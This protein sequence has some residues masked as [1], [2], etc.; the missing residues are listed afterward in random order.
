MEI[1]VKERESNNLNVTVGGVLILPENY[2]SDEKYHYYSTTISFYKYAKKQLEIDYLTKP[3]ALIEQR[4]G[5]WFAPVLMFTSIAL[6][7]NPALISITCGIISNYVTDFFK[8]QATPKIRL[9]VIHKETKSTKLTEI[10]YEGDLEGLNKL[11]EAILKI[12]SKGS[13]NE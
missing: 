13:K 6:V 8:G 4:S 11:E 10:S 5:E 2:L 7:E 1:E 12:A 9:K 3:E